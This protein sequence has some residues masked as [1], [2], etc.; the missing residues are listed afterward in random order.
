MI[1]A[2]ATTF[3]VSKLA[4]GIRFTGERADQSVPVNLVRKDWRTSP[5]RR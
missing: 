1:A 5:C 2:V 4:A 3:E